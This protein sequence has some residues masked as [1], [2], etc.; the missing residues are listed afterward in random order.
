MKKNLFRSHLL[1]IFNFMI[2]LGLFADLNNFVSPTNITRYLEPMI[3]KFLHKWRTTNDF[4]YQQWKKN[5]S[6]SELKFFEEIMDHQRIKPAT[7][8][9]TWKKTD[10]I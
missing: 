1:K 9:F 6:M 10:S 5:D 2:C 8:G 4:F 7:P 3:T